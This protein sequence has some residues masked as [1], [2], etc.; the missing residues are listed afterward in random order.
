VR[1]ILDL[2][3]EQM[4]SSLKKLNAA[5]AAGN[6][7]EVD[8]IAHNCYGSSANCGMIAMIAPLRDLERMGREN[9]LGG[10]ADR[11]AEAEKEFER[12]KI[13]LREIMP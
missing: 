10:A 9:Q 8:L 4:E 2:Y 5:I 6:A 1:E 11:V 3:L 12:I 7:S 13:Y